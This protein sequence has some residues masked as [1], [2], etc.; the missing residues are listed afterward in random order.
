MPPARQRQRFETVADDAVDASARGS[1]L[2]LEPLIGSYADRRCCSWQTMSAG[3]KKVQIRQSRSSF[4]IGLSDFD[5][6][7]SDAKKGR[8]GSGIN[9]RFGIAG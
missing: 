4:L 1:Y 5:L 2:I 8:L 7:P 3:G 9:G 6:S